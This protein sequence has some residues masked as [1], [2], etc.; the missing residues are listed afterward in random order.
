MTADMEDINSIFKA[1][2]EHFMTRRG[3]QAALSARSGVST[4]QINDI[5]KGRHG[6]TEEK[7]RVLAAALGYPGR[8]YEDFLDLGRAV[9][10]GQPIPATPADQLSEADLAASGCFLVP[11]EPLG[12]PAAGGPGLAQVGEAAAMVVHGPTLG[13][14]SG[15]HLRAFLV[16]GDSMEPLFAQGGMVLADLTENRAENLREGSAYV[17]CCDGEEDVKY[18]RWAEK[19]RLLALESENKFYRPVF[20]KAREVTLIGRVIWSCRRHE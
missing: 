10:A 18:L 3:D 16:G 2:L 4:T 15:R 17:V 5:L 1:G 20:R 12:R 13:R 7:R 8:Q 14:K 9:L 19:G 11:L 6:C